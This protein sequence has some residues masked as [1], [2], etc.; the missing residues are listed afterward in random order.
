MP[1]T[2]AG[3]DLFYSYSSCSDAPARADCPYQNDATSAAMRAARDLRV[4]LRAVCTELVPDASG[5]RVVA[6][7]A[8]AVTGAGPSSWRFSSLVCY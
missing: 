4:L 8:A 5:R 2:V 1:S 3:S 6:L 7:R